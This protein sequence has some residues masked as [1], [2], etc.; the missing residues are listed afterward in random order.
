MIQV[1]KNS[2][3]FYR[4]AFN[5]PLAYE[6]EPIILGYWY[7]LLELELELENYHYYLPCWFLLVNHIWLILNIRLVQVWVWFFLIFFLAINSFNFRIKEKL[8][9]MFFTSCKRKRATLNL[10]RIGWRI[11]RIFKINNL[12]RRIKVFSKCN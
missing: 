2:S 5:F 4:F 11:T 9:G 1:L 7:L 12:N 3:L 8:L 10:A 6:R